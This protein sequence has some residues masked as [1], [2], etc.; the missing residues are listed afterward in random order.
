[1][2]ESAKVIYMGVISSSRRVDWYH[3]LL[4]RRWTPRHLDNS[5]R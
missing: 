3:S 5:A 1:M 2:L 4:W